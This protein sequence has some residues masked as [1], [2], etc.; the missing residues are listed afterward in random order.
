MIRYKIDVLKALKEKG[1]NTNK[2]RKE[3]LIG[4]ARLQDIRNGGLGS[5]NTINTICNLLSC[6][7]GDILEYL[8]DPDNDDNI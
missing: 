8:P 1:Y 7:P 5:K 6:Q 4:E 3:K 2:I